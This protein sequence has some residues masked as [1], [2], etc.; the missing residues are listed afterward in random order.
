MQVRLLRELPDLGEF[1]HCEEVSEILL[2]ALLRDYSAFPLLEQIPLWRGL[3]SLPGAG[4]Q[5]SHLLSS[6]LPGELG[7][8]DRRPG[9]GVEPSRRQQ[10]C[11]CPSCRLPAPTAHPLEQPLRADTAWKQ[12]GGG[13]GPRRP[14]QPPASCRGWDNEDRPCF[15]V[16][17][18]LRA[19]FCLLLGLVLLSV[20]SVRF[21]REA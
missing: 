7:G 15:P 18:R 9:R 21:P 4:L 16:L 12:G 1:K 13:G 10:N 11:R 3:M 17:S 19:W 6:A 5:T 8:T 14:P 2:Q 20:G